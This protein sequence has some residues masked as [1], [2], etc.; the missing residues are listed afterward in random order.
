M[1]PST[2]IEYE[3]LLKPWD[4]EMSSFADGIV[5]DSTESVEEDGALSTVD[6]VE[7]GVE[8]RGADA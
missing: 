7:G 3:R 1:G 5:D 6:G 2:D 8:N 4:E